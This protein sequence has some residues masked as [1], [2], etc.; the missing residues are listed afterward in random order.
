MSVSLT[1]AFARD[2]DWTLITEID[3]PRAQALVMLIQTQVDQP[4]DQK[5]EEYY[6]WLLELNRML[7]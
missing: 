2:P 1:E 6:G 5:G 3:R 4:R 7:T